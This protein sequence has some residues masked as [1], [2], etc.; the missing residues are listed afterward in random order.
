MNAIALALR[1]RTDAAWRAR[2][3]AALSRFTERKPGAHRSISTSGRCMATQRARAVPARRSRRPRRH[4][5]RA[6]ASAGSTSCVGPAVSTDG[7]MPPLAARV[8]EAVQ[9]VRK[10]RTDREVVVLAMQQK[11]DA[12]DARAQLGGVVAELPRGFDHAHA[13]GLG[14]ARLVF[15]RARNGADRHAGRTGDIANGCGHR[16]EA[17]QSGWPHG[18]SSSG[19]CI[20]KRGSKLPCLARFDT[21]K[22]PYIGT[23]MGLSCCLVKFTK[24]CGERGLGVRGAVTREVDRSANGRRKSEEGR[25]A[26]AMQARAIRGGRREP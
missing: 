9:D 18:V 14:Q 17:A 20:V 13:G 24:Q 19:D 23:R 15:Q 4:P 3:R 21:R 12:A 16:S 2:R 1:A 5:A 8:L 6:G 25:G 22:Y 10:E 11:S 7:T 26:R